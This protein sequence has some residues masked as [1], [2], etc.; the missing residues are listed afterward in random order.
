MYL[1]RSVKGNGRTIL[2][3][4]LVLIVNQSRDI[5]NF[6]LTATADKFYIFTFRIDR[7]FGK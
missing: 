4:S 5:V 6:L 2:I 7:T 1:S 3:K